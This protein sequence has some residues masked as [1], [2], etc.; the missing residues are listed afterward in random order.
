MSGTNKSRKALAAKMATV[1]PLDRV[2]D[3]MRVSAGTQVT[4]RMVPDHLAWLQQLA[5]ERGAS[6]SAELGRII[7][8]AR[9]QG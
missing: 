3:A 6:T 4:L 1:Q 2:P 7:A 5:R 8:K 9:T